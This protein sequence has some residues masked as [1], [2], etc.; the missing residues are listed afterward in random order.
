MSVGYT[1]ETVGSSQKKEQ[2]NTSHVFA[3]FLNWLDSQVKR[4]GTQWFVWE[5][6]GFY[7]GFGEKECISP[8]GSP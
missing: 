3:C 4:V 7:C 8:I 5:T 6:G 2:K 1:T